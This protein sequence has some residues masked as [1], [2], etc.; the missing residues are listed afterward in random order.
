MHRRVKGFWVAGLMDHEHAL[1]ANTIGAFLHGDWGLF[2]V[3]AGA[4]VDG[5]CGWFRFRW[6]ETALAFPLFTDCD[7]RP[8]T[9]VAPVGKLYGI[10]QPVKCLGTKSMVPPRHNHMVARHA[11]A[12]TV[13]QQFPRGL[14]CPWR[15]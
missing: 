5:L 3:G 12:M 8:A 4:L 6:G 2:T 11:Q 14:S 7:D 15:R 9:W 1:S 10:L 13:S